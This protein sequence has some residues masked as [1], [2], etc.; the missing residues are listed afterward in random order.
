M[1]WH[2]TPIVFVLSGESA[3]LT[4]RCA[5]LGVQVCYLESENGRPLNGQYERLSSMRR[6]IA[7]ESI[8]HFVW[9]SAPGQAIMTFAMRVAP[10]QIF[11]TLKFH[12]F[13]LPETDEY[14][15]PGNWAET[16]RRMDG[17]VGKNHRLSSGNKNS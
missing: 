3:E 6:R 17:G 15:Q 11:W 14:I 10:V 5:E 4:R 12:P 13:R 7:A 2:D 1:P 9:L 16:E 8:S